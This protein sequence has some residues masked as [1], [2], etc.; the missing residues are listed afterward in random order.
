MQPFLKPAKGQEETSA[1]VLLK[2][3]LFKS[4]MLRNALSFQRSESR[5][6][7]WEGI[8]FYVSKMS[9]CFCFPLFL[10]SYKLTSWDIRIAH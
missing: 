5:N 1:E 7:K 4:K 10:L 9:I 3:A 8:G 2:A 6:N